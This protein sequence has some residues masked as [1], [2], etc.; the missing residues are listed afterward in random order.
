MPQSCQK[1]PATVLECAL[2]G[3]HYATTESTEPNNYF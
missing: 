3:K 1:L 2:K